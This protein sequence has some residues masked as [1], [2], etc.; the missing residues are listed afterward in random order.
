MSGD[1]SLDFARKWNDGMIK[2]HDLNFH[3]LF[4]DLSMSSFKPFLGFLP[5]ILEFLPRVIFR[6]RDLVAEHPRVRPDRSTGYNNFYLSGFLVDRLDG[7]SPAARCP[8]DSP[9]PCILRGRRSSHLSKASMG[10]RVL[11]PASPLTNSSRYVS[12]FVHYSRVRLLRHL[13]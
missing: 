2:I 3:S 9:H 10:T 12:C 4:S 11:D 5:Y 7:L 6:L 13:R 8:S 1:R